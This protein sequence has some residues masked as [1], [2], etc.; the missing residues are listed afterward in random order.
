MPTI[1]HHHGRELKSVA[2][3]ASPARHNCGVGVVEDSADFD[4]QDALTAPR[5]G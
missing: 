1:L 5:F 4:P 2:R 3:D